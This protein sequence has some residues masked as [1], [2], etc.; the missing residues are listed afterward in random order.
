MVQRAKFQSETLTKEIHDSQSAREEEL[1]TGK[2]IY[3]RLFELY[4]YE[5]CV[6]QAD[7]LEKFVYKISSSLKRVSTPETDSY[8]RN[9]VVEKKV[10]K[11]MATHW[12]S[13]SSKR[14]T[15]ESATTTAKHLLA[16]VTNS[17]IRAYNA[18]LL[19]PD[20]F[21]IESVEE[22]SPHTKEHSGLLEVVISQVP[23]RQRFDDYNRMKLVAAEVLLEGIEQKLLSGKLATACLGQLVNDPELSAIEPRT[24]FVTSFNVDFG[25]KILRIDADMVVE[26]DFWD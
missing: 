14:V 7:F 17:S 13:G 4:Q 19:V 20:S 22:V 25:F 23:Y 6:I 12:T 8:Y 3:P 10:I 21:V 5:K 9:S 2:L 15:L 1:K 26:R 11:A 18:S 24:M 16:T